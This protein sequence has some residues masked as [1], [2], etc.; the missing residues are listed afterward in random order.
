MITSV[1][2]GAQHHVAAGQ[3]G[4]FEVEGLAQFNGTDLT[5]TIPAPFPH[6]SN[7]DI[8]LI[9]GPDAVFLDMLSSLVDNHITPRTDGAVD[10]FAITNG[11]SGYTGTPTIAF[12]GGGGT[13]AAATAIVVSN[14]VTGIQLTNGGSGYTSAPTLAFSGGSGTGAAATAV[15]SNGGTLTFTRPSSSPTANLAF[16]Y[17]MRGRQ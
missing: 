15:I 12:S 7:F 4:Y 2:Q 9:G 3:N 5:G 14:V 8:G 10:H 1:A 13:G 6:M 11:G 17:K 16:F